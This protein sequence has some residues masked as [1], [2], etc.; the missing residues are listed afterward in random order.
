MSDEYLGFRSGFTA[1][2]ASR[3]LPVVVNDPGDTLYGDGSPE[4]VVNAFPGMRYIDNGTS[5]LWIK[6]IGVQSLGWI[7]TGA[8]GSGAVSISGTSGKVFSTPADPN[9]VL[10]ANGAAVAIGSGDVAGKIWV[11]SS[12]GTSD[13]DWNL[14]IG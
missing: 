14:L 12:S 8:F 2:S 6:A 5:A 10:S 9:G 11:K 13:S 7:E 1:P 3:A 4:G